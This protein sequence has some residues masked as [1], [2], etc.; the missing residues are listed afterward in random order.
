ME[1]TAQQAAE[2]IKAIATDEDIK[3][4]SPNHACSLMEYRCIFLL[5][6]QKGDI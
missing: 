1:S 3:Q 4:K 5:S 2:K 6:S